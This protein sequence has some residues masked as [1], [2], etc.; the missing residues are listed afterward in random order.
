MRRRKPTLPPRTDTYVSCGTCTGG[1]MPTGTGKVQRCICWLMFFEP[2]R[3]TA[4]T[5]ERKDQT[6]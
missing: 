1:W 6:A 5:V 2:E 3:F 4:V